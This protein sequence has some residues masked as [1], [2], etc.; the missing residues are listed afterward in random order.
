MLLSPQIVQRYTFASEGNISYNPTHN[1]LLG[2][3][4]RE[5][6]GRKICIIQKLIHEAQKGV[7]EME[8]VE[9]K[10]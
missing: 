5:S 9:A 4:G 7:A 3:L 1:T 8:N 6:R 2:N 10:A